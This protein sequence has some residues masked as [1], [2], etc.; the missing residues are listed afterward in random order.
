LQA[1]W[2]REVEFGRLDE[3]SP[4]NSYKFL[5]SAEHLERS[6]YSL[7]VTDIHLK[8]LNRLYFTVES[9]EL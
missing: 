8:M 2:Y 6:R 4:K 5:V 1:S 7:E 3:V 9:T